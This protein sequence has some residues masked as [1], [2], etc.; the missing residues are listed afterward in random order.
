MVQL[1][2]KY[3]DYSCKPDP[4]GWALEKQR[5]FF[6]WWQKRQAR[7]LKHEIDSACRYWLWT[8]R[9]THASDVTMLEAESPVHSQQG[10][11]YLSS[12]NVR[13]WILPIISMSLKANS[14]SEHSDK[15]PSHLIPETKK[16]RKSIHSMLT[17]WPVEVWA[18]KQVLF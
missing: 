5:D 15:I 16:E 13:K 10:D 18:N 17:F 2:L 1:T 14:P 9:R 4:I 3:K 6:G 12:T 11:K 8:W 7:N